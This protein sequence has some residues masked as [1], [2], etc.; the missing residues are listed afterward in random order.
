MRLDPKTRAENLMIVD[1][2]RNDL[3][4][5]RTGS[6]SKVSKL[7]EIETYSMLLQTTL[8]LKKKRTINEFF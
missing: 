3:A 7:F 6:V 8:R 4:H 1:L 2:I 5:I